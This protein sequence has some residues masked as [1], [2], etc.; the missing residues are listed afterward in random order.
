MQFRPDDLKAARRISRTGTI[1]MVFHDLKPG[2][3]YLNLVQ[4][5]KTKGANAKDQNLYAN[6]TLTRRRNFMLFQI[7]QAHKKNIM[8]TTM[9]P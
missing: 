2:S 9:G 6:F 8:L 5:M 3:P 4:A 7:R 1:L